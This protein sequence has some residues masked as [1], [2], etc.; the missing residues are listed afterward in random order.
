MVVTT[1][2]DVV[3][4]DLRM[5]GVDGISATERIVG[6]PKAPVVVALT[7][8]DADSWVLGAL[9]A[10][11]GGFLLKSTPPEDLVSLVRVVAD[12][13]TVMSSEA[14]RRLVATSNDGHQRTVEA[15]QRTAELTEREREVLACLGEGSSN[16]TIARQLFL[17]EA[18]VKSYV[19]R[20]LDKLGR[21]NRTQAGLLAREA[22]IVPGPG[23]H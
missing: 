7:T 16:A 23:P 1:R 11:A 13:H 14:T 3:L 22:G 10:G 5:A 12:G 18:T 2:P 20:M 9:R 17:S 6:L 19:S 8:F 4:M 15:R 21:D